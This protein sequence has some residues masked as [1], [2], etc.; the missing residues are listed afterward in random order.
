MLSSR[1]KFQTT[2]DISDIDKITSILEKIP[3]NTQ[4]MFF[5]A[6]TNE[7]TFEIAYTY[8]KKGGLE[9]KNSPFIVLLDQDDLT[10]EGINQYYY[11]CQ[12]YD[13]KLFV[14]D[15]ILKRCNISQSIIYANNIRTA[16]KLK[17]KLFE[18]DKNRVICVIHGEMNGDL[19][20]EIFK[21][22]KLGKYR[23]MVSTDL[24]SRGIDITGINL[25]INFEMPDR[26]ET[27][28]HRSGRSGRYGKKGTTINLIFY[29][30]APK[31]TQINNSSKSAVQELPS[32]LE[33][34]V[35]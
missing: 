16:E 18:L 19:R 29:D 1:N 23:L 30:E 32:D 24:T 6:T 13:E 35:L 15:D 4:R 22:F 31:I 11:K 7:T 14:L 28:I 25:V 2:V 26:L 12:N 21:D 20:K 33:H 5:S 8:C 9:C 34:L 10:L 3:K 17:E 27:Y